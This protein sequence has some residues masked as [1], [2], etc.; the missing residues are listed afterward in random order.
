M[1][2][3]S[4]ELPTETLE[5]LRAIAVSDLTSVTRLVQRAV[6]DW[7]DARRTTEAAIMLRAKREKKLEELA[8]KENQ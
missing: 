1:V 3:L 6:R 5:T 2:K 7:M 8:E 4:I